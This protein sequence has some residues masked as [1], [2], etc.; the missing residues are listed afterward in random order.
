MQQEHELRNL[1]YTAIGSIDVQENVRMSSLTTF[2]IGGPAR[3]VI[4][5]ENTRELSGALNVLRSEDIGFVV[6]GRGS[7]ILACDEGY[8]GALIKTQNYFNRTIVQGNV[9][10]AESGVTLAALCRTAQLHG[11]SGLEFASGIPGTVGGAVY[12]NAGAYGGEIRDVLQ[13][14]TVMDMTGQLLH[15]DAAELQFGKRSSILQ[16]KNWTLVQAVFQLS[17]GDPEKIDEHMK[18]LNQRRQ[19]RQPLE[20]PSAGSV[21]KRPEGYYAGALI[22]QAGLSGRRVGGAMVSP[23]HAGFIVNTGSATAADVVELVHIIKETVLHSS[24]VA[25]EC[26]IRYLGPEGLGPLR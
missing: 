24:G 5:P 8:H 23:K 18:E 14:A 26:E 1:L 3:Y 10:T 15:L 9:I 7:N 20:Y 2:R 16:K 25:L 11:L 13:E 19:D 21:F 4:A 17:E 22:E 12:M 6:L